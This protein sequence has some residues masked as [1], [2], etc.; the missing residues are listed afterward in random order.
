VH[1]GERE[2]REGGKDGQG[3]GFEDEIEIRIGRTEERG[4]MESFAKQP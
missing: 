4:N 3:F 1:E 2:G